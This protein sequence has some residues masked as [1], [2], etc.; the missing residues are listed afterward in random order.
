MIDHYTEIKQYFFLFYKCEKSTI[1]IYI[2]HWKMIIP[3]R[4]TTSLQDIY[5]NPYDFLKLYFLEEFYSNKYF[6]LQEIE[7]WPNL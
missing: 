1:K 5:K 3:K 4:E 7:F 6:F 2:T